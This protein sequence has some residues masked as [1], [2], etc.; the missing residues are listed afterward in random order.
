MR[1]T[2]VGFSFGQ[3]TGLG[4]IPFAIR[5]TDSMPAIFT[6]IAN[7]DTYYS[8]NP[9]D[10]QN[11]ALGR[12]RE[13]VG[14]GP[15][16]GDPVGVT[17]AFIRNS[18]NDDWIPIA[19]NFVGP[20][21]PAGPAGGNTVI[22]QRLG[23]DV[24]VAATTLNFLG[25]GVAVADAGA[26]KNITV[27]TLT[28]RN[29]GVV[30]PARALI[31][32]F[33]GTGVTASGT[34]T[35][36]VITIPGGVTVQDEGVALT[37]AGT[38]LNFTGTGVTVTG[39]G[40]TKTINISGS[41]LSLAGIPANTLLRVNA[42]GDA[43]VASSLT[44]SD[45]EVDSTKTVLVPDAQGVMFGGIRVTNGGFNI[46]ASTLD[47]R[48]F[49][50]IASEL[51]SGGSV[52]P[53]WISLAGQTTTPSAANTSE[54]FTDT[55]VQFKVVNANTG[56]AERYTFNAAAAATDCNLIIR[57][58]SHS[59]PEI[60]NF[61]RANGGTGFD[62]VENSSP[63]DLP[64]QGLFFRAGVVLYV[65]I[66]PGSGNIS[67]RGQTLTVDGTSETVPFTDVFGRLSTDVGIFTE[68]DG[69]IDALSEKTTVA[70]G[71]F[72]VIE[73]SADG[74]S[75]KKVRIGNLPAG[76]GTSPVGTD[77]RHGLSNQSDPALVDF[78]ALTDVASPTDP[79]TIATGTTTA[80]QYFHILNAN[81]HPIE[82]IEDTVLSQTVYTRGAPSGNIFTFVADSRTEGMITYNALTIGPLNAGVDESYI[83]RFS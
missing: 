68:D 78:N 52:R 18:A 47:G 1:E 37:S 74:F 51:I 75:K 25:G 69:E 4:A 9:G 21:G 7:R 2:G 64:G 73:D 53:N 6:S 54:T 76:G 70:N 41:G 45:T 28:V 58:T 39:T 11:T 50:P 79:I 8:T 44:E 57:L 83:V 48:V 19:T 10:L 35:T 24:G 14:I 36:K 20:E 42:A 23:A 46:A 62:L 60:F 27:E 13:A 33:V 67:L 38:T 43:V 55:Q 80:G 26:T 59:G 77:L 82:S 34:G 65:T 17:A 3:G 30:L 22:V 66:L 32:D 49:Y 71:D 56:V 16:D 40:S 63:V 31:L 81:T 5:S 15:N 72:V 12:G 29:Q 61:K